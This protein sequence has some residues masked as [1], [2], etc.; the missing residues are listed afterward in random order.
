VAAALVLA[1]FT[2]ARRRQGFLRTGIGL[3]AV[4]LAGLTLAPNLAIAVLCNATVGFGLILFMATSQSVVQLSV[5]DRNR[6][7]VMGIWSMVING[8]VPLGNLLAGPAADRWSVPSVLTVQGL[9]CGAAL[10][11][12]LLFMRLR[13][14]PATAPDG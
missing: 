2:A 11:I 1:S 7:R 5:D 9:G 14:E 10:M 13:R 6:G 3:T 4:G 12:A 8:F